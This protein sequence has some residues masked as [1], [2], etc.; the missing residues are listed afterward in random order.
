MQK[1]LPLIFGMV[2]ALCSGAALAGSA[3]HNPVTGASANP[4]SELHLSHKCGGE[5]QPPCPHEQG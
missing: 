2:L 5:G 1:T 3:H 4:D